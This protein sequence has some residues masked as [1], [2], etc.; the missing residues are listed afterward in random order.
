MKNSCSCLFLA[1][2]D[3]WTVNSVQNLVIFVLLSVYYSIFNFQETEKEPFVKDVLPEELKKFEKLLA[4]RAGGKKFILGDKVSEY[5]LT[6]QNLW[7]ILLLFEF[8]FRTVN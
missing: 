5:C 3:W 1:L 4:T 8:V 7:N 6:D 2:L